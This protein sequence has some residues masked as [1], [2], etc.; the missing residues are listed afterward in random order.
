MLS[1]PTRLRVWP[2]TNRAG[3]VGPVWWWLGYAA[4]VIA[5]IVA[6]GY[7]AVRVVR[8]GGRLLRELERAG[9]EVGDRLDRLSSD[10]DRRELMGD[11]ENVGAR[12]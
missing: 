12:S 2:V 6:L 10:L 11:H 8:K 4:L 1:P 3:K 9:T 5:E 7:L